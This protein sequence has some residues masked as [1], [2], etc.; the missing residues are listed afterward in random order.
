MYIYIYIERERY[1]DILIH[2]EIF[3]CEEPIARKQASKQAS[4]HAH[5]CHP[6]EVCSLSLSLS[7]YVCAVSVRCMRASKLC[8]CGRCSHVFV[9]FVPLGMYVRRAWHYHREFTLARQSSADG[10]GLGVSM[11]FGRLYLYYHIIILI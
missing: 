2:D 9:R 10:D 7:M 6:L 3:L 4:T 11:L 1:N 8:M 5:C